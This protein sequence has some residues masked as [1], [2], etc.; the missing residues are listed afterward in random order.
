MGCLFFIFGLITPRL[1]LFLLWMFSNWYDG[2]FHG[3]LIPILGFL[4]LPYTL[5]WYTIVI[6]WYSGTWGFWQVAILILAIVTDLSASG[7]SARHGKR[8]Y[9][10]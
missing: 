6:N 1:V 3:A 8:Y 5:L 4:F 10:D 9:K 7:G 2:I